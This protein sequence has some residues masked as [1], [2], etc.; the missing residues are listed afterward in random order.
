MFCQQQANVV[1]WRPRIKPFT[2]QENNVK[3][4][5]VNGSTNSAEPFWLKSF[6]LKIVRAWCRHRPGCVFSSDMPVSESAAQ[7][8]TIDEETSK[9]AAKW[10][11]IVDTVLTFQEAKRTEFWAGNFFVLLYPEFPASR[12]FLWPEKVDAGL[13]DM[14]GILA[15]MKAA[16]ASDE[17]LL[18][19]AAKAYLIIRDALKDSRPAKWN[20]E[21]ASRNLLRMWGDVTVCHCACLLGVTDRNSFLWKLDDA[22]EGQ[23]LGDRIFCSQMQQSYHKVLRAADGAFHSKSALVKQK[24][25]WTRPRAPRN[26]DVSD[27]QET[28]TTDDSAAAA[29]SDA[30]EIKQLKVA[31]KKMQDQMNGKKRSPSIARPDPLPDAWAQFRKSVPEIKQLKVA[32][33]KMQDQMNGKESSPSTA[34]PDHLPDAWAQFCKSVPDG[35]RAHVALH[36]DDRAAAASSDAVDGSSM[37]KGAV[38]CSYSEGVCKLVPKSHDAANR[39]WHGSERRQHEM[40]GQ[41]AKH[42]WYAP[43]AWFD[44][45]YAAQGDTLQCQYGHTLEF[46]QEHMQF[47]WFRNRLCPMCNGKL[48]VKAA[49]WHQV[50]WW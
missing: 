42:G 39:G 45:Q 24:R 25:G 44:F 17:C 12:M 31:N 20:G 2:P 19:G 35:S 3:Q 6:G 37:Y 14:M 16:R 36:A 18:N 30:V 15:K 43:S 21:K 46:Q 10:N 26:R 8:D 33:K 32:N 22:F 49:A 41:A 27:A 13:A 5:L 4:S 9:T 7:L 28:A 48:Y 40:F 34:R 47:A 11:L 23:M 50:N 1:A 38:E 29:S